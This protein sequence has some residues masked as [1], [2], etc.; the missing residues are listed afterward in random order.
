MSKKTPQVAFSKQM[1]RNDFSTI[2]M[3][4]P[5]YDPRLMNL[6]KP[7][8][9]GILHFGSSTLG[10]AGKGKLVN[11]AADES[12]KKRGMLSTGVNID[13][14]STGVQAQARAE[15]LDKITKAYSMQAALMADQN[16]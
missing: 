2:K 11:H 8:A 4:E 3:S 15:S 1:A 16:S 12:K 6:V 10:R 5:I 13:P 14:V 9:Q 7:K